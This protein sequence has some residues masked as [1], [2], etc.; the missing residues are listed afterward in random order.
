[1]T[2][3]GVRGR[4]RRAGDGPPGRLA[5]QDGGGHNDGAA[6]EILLH[7]C[8]WGSP[9]RQNCGK[10]AGRTVC[11]STPLSQLSLSLSFS[12]SLFLGVSSRLHTAHAMTRSLHDEGYVSS[13]HSE[14][15]AAAPLQRRRKAA[16]VL[17]SACREKGGGRRSLPGERYSSAGALDEQPTAPI[18]ACGPCQLPLEV[19]R[20]NY[21]PL[22][23]SLTLAG[24][25]MQAD[26]GKRSITAK[27]RNL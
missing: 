25:V 16:Q 17:W 2:G 22:Q 10:C 8:D 20:A 13:H 24:S 21:V 4:C 27:T 26:V 23:V 12:L 6:E 9:R 7:C 19:R 14:S 11:K 18:C 15:V 3:Y 1:M 5:L